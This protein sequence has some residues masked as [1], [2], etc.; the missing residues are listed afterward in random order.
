MKRFDLTINK[1]ELELIV[2]PERGHWYML[3]PKYGQYA[4][5]PIGLGHFERNHNFL[6]IGTRDYELVFDCDDDATRWD[7]WSIF[8]VKKQAYLPETGRI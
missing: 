1:H 6:R 8:D 4:S 7:S 3:F 5:G 2:D